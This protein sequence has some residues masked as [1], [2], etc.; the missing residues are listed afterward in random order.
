MVTP[1]FAHLLDESS[2]FLKL[3]MSS[4]FGTQQTLSPTTPRKSIF[5]IV[6]KLPG[7]DTGLQSPPASE[8]VAYLVSSSEYISAEARGV[9]DDD[10]IPSMV[11]LKMLPGRIHDRK[12]VRVSSRVKDLSGKTSIAVPLANTLFL[13]GRTSTLVETLWHR[14]D[15]GTLTQGVSSQVKAL[16][17]QLSTTMA[18]WFHYL[19]LTL[20]TAS[21]PVRSA[22]GNVLRK[23]EVD[24][25]DAPAS[26]ELEKAVAES[27]LTTYA[28]G[29]RA[30]VYATIAPKERPRL[31]K[32]PRPW[33]IL[34]G[35]GFYR[36]TGGGGGWGQKQ[37]LLSLDATRSYE[38]E[39]EETF[40][41][42]F[43]DDIDGDLPNFLQPGKSLAQP[44]DKVAF[45]SGVSNSQNHHYAITT[46]ESLGWSSPSYNQ[47]ML[48]G[49]VP[50]PPPEGTAVT[51]M[52]SVV[53]VPQSFG[54]LSEKGLALEFDGV[55]D[56]QR[57]DTDYPKESKTTEGNGNASQEKVL[58]KA[59]LE[60]PG[61]WIGSRVWTQNQEMAKRRLENNGRS[62]LEV[63]KDASL[64][65]TE[66][67]DVPADTYQ[68]MGRA[69]A[70]LRR[71]ARRK[72]DAALM[73]LAREMG[74]TNATRYESAK[75]PASQ[76][77]DLSQPKAETQTSG[78]EIVFDM[79]VPKPED[80]DEP[81]ARGASYNETMHPKG[82]VDFRK[83]E[84]PKHTRKDNAQHIFRSRSTRKKADGAGGAD[85]KPHPAPKVR[86]HFG[87]NPGRSA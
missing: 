48:L 10:S 41:P 20:L 7:V 32:R 62:R 67:D 84:P 8:G 18:S 5:G 78:R 86:Y 46:L 70:L 12:A 36:V 23:V 55:R 69:R 57:E 49:V 6:D 40:P 73:E 2:S 77:G 60:L 83:I 76:A 37:G 44:G 30:Q 68:N 29:A 19:P 1:Q 45:W 82:G 81:M 72:T 28:D 3:A 24:G 87:K 25:A 9:K 38:P 52:P 54:I 47:H 22:M 58:N 34:S 63:Q 14:K 39:H 11:A 17:I 53:H 64:R 85:K 21:R 74:Q 51:G 27:P 15:N 80:P 61:A 33:N 75:P 43:S 66:T 16:N 13:N 71:A 65:T 42:A 56:Q 31:D 59:V 35:L 26:K 79:P 50:P 4:I